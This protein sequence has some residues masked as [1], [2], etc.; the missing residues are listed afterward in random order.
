MA[1][2]TFSVITAIIFFVIGFWFFPAMIGLVFFGS[3]YWYAAAIRWV[4]N[5]ELWRGAQE[6]RAAQTQL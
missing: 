6:G 1:F 5:R 3:A 2:E 4:D